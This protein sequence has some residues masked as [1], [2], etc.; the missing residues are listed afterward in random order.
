MKK[1]FVLLLVIA[2]LTVMAV[3]GLAKE[4]RLTYWTYQELH[5]EFMD[6][7]VEV[8]NEKNPDNQIVLETSVYPY[9]QMHN[10]LLIA[11]QSGV[12]APD[13][14]DIEISKF[15]N[16]LKGKTPQL[17]P[18]NDVVE[19]VLDKT[20]KARFD[21]YSKD[22]KY[23]GMPF[24]VGAE[25]MYYNKEYL[26]AAGVDVDEILTWD[27]YVEAGKKV[28]AA[29]GKPMTTIEVTE[30][31]SYYPLISQ[32]GS[33]IFA[34]DGEVI[35]DNET[36]IKIL[37]F[38]K[39]MIYKHEIAIPAPGGFHHSE[40]YWAFMNNGG[41]ASL[42]MPIWYMGRFVQYMPHLKGKMIIRPLP[43]WEEGGNRSAGM[44][45]TGTVVTIQSKHKDLAVNFLGEAKLSKEASKKLWTVLG[46][47]P[48]RWDV[49]DSPEMK[50]DNDYTDYFGKGI[51]DI[52][53]EIKD[54]INPT[55]ITE[56]YPKAIDLLK[57]NVSFKALKEQSMT[58]EEVLKEAA[59]ELK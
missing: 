42:M 58:P 35:L 18:L 3:S 6:D 38:L 8:W 46:F 16:Y 32:A 19:P 9:D 43:A 28:K 52:L 44:G 45:G 51:F 14:S 26:D 17:V 59:E 20:I 5:K 54:E 33:D 2:M 49:W 27:D 31:W 7:A 48:V 30:H 29:T 36:N 1:V 56:K 25:V 40:E 23:Y 53:L 57:K 15:A 11:L 21:N 37:Q 13:L 39:D 10:K 34:P 55:V 41:A 4:T 22:G 24:H 47:D 12:G 50:A